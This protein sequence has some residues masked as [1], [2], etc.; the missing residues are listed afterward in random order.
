MDV[1]A[2][3]DGRFVALDGVTVG[4]QSHALHYGTSVFE[5]IRAYWDAD[6]DELNIFRADRHYSRL[7]HSAGFYGME[8]P[9]SEEELC[10]IS[11]SLLARDDVRQ[12][13][14]LRPILFKSTETIGVWRADLAD[15]LVIFYV[16]MGKYLAAGGI[17]CCVSSWRRPEGNV[18]PA[19]AKIGG[20]YAAMA[21]ARYDAMANGFD[22]ALMLTGRGH[23]AEGTGENIFLVQDGRLITPAAG[24]DLLA[25]ITR[26]CVIELAT[27]ELG[28]QV[29]ERSV[30]RSELYVS[31]EIFLC[32]TAAEVTP[33]FEIDHRTVGDGGAGPVTTAVGDLYAAVVRGKLAQYRHW[34]LPVYGR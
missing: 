25:G 34:C 13:V 22:E 16:P 26:E 32:G 20:M 23:V 17:R 8:L 18:A 29:V 21:L 12:D 2:F 30:N 6:T 3:Q 1:S 33:V 4:I 24:D 15:S 31:D 7:H 28:L 19:R 9:N 5:G 27:A 11:A 14:Y 10:A